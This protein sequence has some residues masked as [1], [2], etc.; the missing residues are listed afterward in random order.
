MITIYIKGGI[1]NQLFQYAFGKFIADK[2]GKEIQ[3]DIS[4][5]N[6]SDRIFGLNDF[7]INANIVYKQN[8]N[9]IKKI[10]YYAYKFN[11]IIKQRILRKHNIGY[12]K[13]ILSSKANYFDG[14][15]QSYKYLEPLRELLLKEITLKDFQNLNQSYPLIKSI[16]ETESV[17]VHIRRGDYVHNP[18]ARAAHLVCTPEYYILA[19][20]VVRSKLHLPHFFLFSDEID[21]VKDHIQGDDITYVSDPKYRASE[22]LIIMSK[23]KHAI[24]SNSSFSF[25]AAWLMQN[26]SKIVIAPKIWNRRYQKYYA[27]LLPLDWIK[28]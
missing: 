27:D 5:Y 9:I 3:L 2:R 14:Y 20:Q 1:G 13:K 19:M 28:I 8:N 18:K 4:W 25:W 15:F 26:P 24:I 21:W 17:F 23:A 10:K 7:N 22:E 16:E 6:N 11:L 12:S